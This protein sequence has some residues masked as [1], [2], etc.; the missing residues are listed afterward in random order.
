M[1]GVAR[2][3][4]LKAAN[5]RLKELQRLKEELVAL[6]VHDLRN[7]L[8]ALRGNLEFLEGEALDCDE[9]VRDTLGDCRHL[10][11]R[12]LALVGGL[13][14]VAQLEEGILRV[15]PA[16][17]ALAEFVPHCARFHKTDVKA[18][19]LTLFS[20]VNPPDLRGRFDPDLLGRLIENLVE[21]SVRYAPIGGWVRVEAHME[22]S[23]LVF[24]VGNNG[25]PI[26]L[27]ERERIFGKYY[28]I[29]GRRASARANRG[30]GLYFCKLAAEA[31]RGQIWVQETTELPACF[32]VSI[33]QDHS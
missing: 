18:R 5:E 1:S 30:L 32:F 13:L 12:A 21:N 25:P 2:E 10:V 16:E 23:S 31:H 24:L 8:S 9:T 15:A 28:R 33:P 20:E 14:D 26:A 17:V 29:E 7:P 27:E 11:N 22:G 3:A 6:V 4:E 19:R